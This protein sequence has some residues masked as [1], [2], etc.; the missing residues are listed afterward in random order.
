MSLPLCHAN[1]LSCK[2]VRQ[3]LGSKVSRERIGTELEGMFNGEQQRKLQQEHCAQLSSLSAVA[4]L[5]GLPH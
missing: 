4:L 1:P 2:Q 5:R 3:A